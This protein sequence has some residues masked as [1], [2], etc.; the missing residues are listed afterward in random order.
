MLKVATDLKLP[1]AVATQAIAVLGIRG[2]GKT[3]TAGVVAEELL[4]IGQPVVVIDPTDAWW[5]LRSSADGKRPGYPVFIAGGPH[6]DLPL[7]EGDGKALAEFLI[8]EQVSAVLSLRHLRKEAQRRFFV[9]LAEEMYHLKGRPENRSSLTLII[10]E[11]SLFVPQDV[12]G[13]L[14]RSVGAVEDF[15][16][17]G[18]N[19][20]FGIVL[21]NQRA[22]TLNKNCL[23][24]CDTLVIHR[25]PSPQDR[26]AMREWIEENAS[27]E[28]ATEVLASMA[29]L[30]TGEA[31]VWSPGLDICQRT[32]V[33]LRE[34]FD[35][36]RSP[37]IGEAP[38]QP[39]KLAE[40][41]LDQLKTK[42]ATSLE[43][44]RANDPAVLKKRIAELE[45]AK[46]AAAADPAAIDQA[47]QAGAKA[48]QQAAA[49]EIREL[50]KRVQTIGGSLLRIKQ[51]ADGSLDLVN[52]D[53]QP[54]TAQNREPRENITKRAP[55]IGPSA[56]FITKPAKIIPTAAVDV[57][58]G[59]VKLSKAERAILQAMYWLKDE[60]ATTAKVS[61]YADYSS[62]SSTF[63]NALGRLRTLG[64][65]SGWRITAAGE[66]L[67]ATYASE[68]PTGNELL[69]WLNAK[70]SKAERAM[71]YALVEGHPN[72]L[73]KE[74][75]S[76]ATGYSAGS[77]TFDNALG[78]L[79]TLEA[80]EGY[81]RDGGTKAADVFFD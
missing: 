41:D 8:V 51:L 38:R 80:A 64:L 30:Q 56:P 15:V 2:S 52:S 12:R 37:K 6:G 76:E 70:L 24:Q 17:R 9:A 34:T 61:F 21:I 49:G 3:N 16:A 46:P 32:Q 55:N 74:Q 33:R 57:V 35:S 72:R 1:D 42:M 50:R 81:D 44:A 43:Q 13:D 20:G 48:A 25:M 59:D 78:R 73:S 54:A 67:A 22:A 29:K 11:A 39:K 66:E 10:D 28:Q 75:L 27:D 62:G 77:S 58:A 36:S 65:V 71:L 68:K 79:R 53:L 40:V 23:T 18:R 5:G 26:K 69:H 7:A 45:K 14:A 31:W 63:D 47:R 60:H 4:K 19:V